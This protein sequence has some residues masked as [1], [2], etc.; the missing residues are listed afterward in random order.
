[1]DAPGFEH[2]I[3]RGESGDTDGNETE[4]KIS[5]AL[6]RCSQG[7][8]ST[9]EKVTLRNLTLDVEFGDVT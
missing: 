7:S 9:T 8:G 2:S 1:M 4:A 6:C 5:R 3:V